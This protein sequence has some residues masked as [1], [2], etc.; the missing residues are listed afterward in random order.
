MA[1]DLFV[2]KGDDGNLWIS[3]SRFGTAIAICRKIDGEWFAAEDDSFSGQ[4]GP[5]SSL[6]DLVDHVE[7]NNLF[8]PWGSPGN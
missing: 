5:F 3:S 6:D 4:T 1:E 2:E 7:K 8:G